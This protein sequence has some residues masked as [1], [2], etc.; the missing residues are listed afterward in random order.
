MKPLDSSDLIWTRQPEAFS[1]SDDRISITTMPY[2]DLWQKTYY[3]FVNDNAPRFA[4][5]NQ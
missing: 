1:I 4:D 2:T 3:H 5:G